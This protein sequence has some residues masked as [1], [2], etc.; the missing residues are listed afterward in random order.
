M[1]P[2]RVLCV[3]RRTKPGMA[4]SLLNPAWTAGRTEP[5][6]G[7]HAVVEVDNLRLEC[8]KL[9]GE[10]AWT[11]DAAWGPRSYPIF[12][13][14]YGARCLMTRV[15]KADIAAMLDEKVMAR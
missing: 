7:L 12:A 9:D 6:E 5:V 15:L 10:D 1:L 13:N 3:E 8:S 14:G 11:I 4:P 2:T